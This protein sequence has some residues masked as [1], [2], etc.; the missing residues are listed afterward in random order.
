M[1]E[2]MN[3]IRILPALLSLI[4]LV[5][6]GCA[7]YDAESKRVDDRIDEIENNRIPSIDKQL[8]KIN[9]SL[10][11][12]E[13]TDLE[14]K[15]MIES[16]DKTADDLR[17]DIGENENRVSEVRSELEKAV[18]ELQDSDKTNK[19][20]LIAAINEAKATVLANLEAMRTE[21]Q[22]KLS[23]IDEMISNLKD[24]DQE[25]EKQISVLKTYV[26]DE[27]KGIRD[28]ATATFATLEQYNGIVERIGGINT[29]MSEL[30]KSLSDLETRLTNKFDEDLK[31]AVSD[32][33]SK[34]GEEV[35]GLNGRIDKEVSD[36]TQAYT[37]AIA[38][39]RAEIES[40]W[41]EK[42]KT[43]L[44][45]LEKSLKLWVNEKLTAYWTI[46]ETK[47][48]LEAQ[49]KDL[50]N[51]LK[52]QEAYLK[53][54][55]DA[56][57]GEIKDLKEA[58]TETE[59]ALADNAKSLEDLF[60]ELE[61]AKKDIKAAYEAVI[62]DA[63][64]SLEGILDDELDDEIES[65]NNSID[66]RVEALES[67]IEKCKDDLASIIK[68]VE[69]AR[70]K[71]RNVISSFVYFPTYS[72]GSVDV[73]CEGV[74][75]SL[76]L[77]FEVR[78]FSAAEALNVGNVSIL[79]QSVEPKDDVIP[80]KLNGITSTGNGI[81]LMDI[82]ASDLPLIFTNGSRKFNVLVSIKDASKGWDMISGFIPIVPVVVTNP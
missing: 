55:I 19:E 71:I 80:L 48:A 74:K 27:L 39:T 70:T 40:A 45:E 32:L 64:T 7:D 49:K 18:K 41:T 29:E 46:E 36:L 28:W 50:E 53:E 25:L 62:K 47:A 3:I 34:I 23:D 66:E 35:S 30:K 81:V 65:L 21:M 17:K 59:N 5:S 26:D 60:S 68:D 44:E 52:A 51:Q 14:I 75:K 58:L 15:K 78:P 4:L 72:D 67:R 24:K 2:S 43:S 22:G 11:E 8:E 12:L 6:S 9:A 56:N 13:R 1:E 73:F 76:T 82:D 77:K 20:E 57:A 16:L 42:V 38:K 61:Q 37:S 33:E 69:D 79:T 31:K 54:L 63:I 10:P